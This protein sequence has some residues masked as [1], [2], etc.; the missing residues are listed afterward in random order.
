MILPLV[1]VTSCSFD[2]TTPNP[3]ER[4]P[5]ENLDELF[6]RQTLTG[7]TK[8]ID[9]SMDE[10]IITSSG[11][12]VSIEAGS[13]LKNNNPVVG[14][15]SVVT[16]ELML[17]SDMILLDKPSTSG[18]SILEYGAILVFNAF[19]DSSGIDLQNPIS[20]TL[21]INNQVSG[22]GDMNHYNR[23]GSWQ[24]VNNS[25]VVVDAGEMTLQF[26]TEDNGWMCGAMQTNFNDLTTIEA[27][28]F[29]YGTILTDIAGFVILSDF[30]TVIKMD[31]DIN[32]V[33]VSKSNIPKGVE[34]SIV[35]IAMDH[36]QL[37]IGIETMDITTDLS[38]EIKM[39]EV[40][41]QELPS[42][43]QMIN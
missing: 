6:A 27:S 18:N 22:L 3:K 7:E 38:L 15:V 34:A 26:D 14:N 23:S 2:D 10:T 11:A 5:Y 39:N 40:T 12:K 24:Q 1:I 19:K 16:R 41:E 35:I 28:P 25:P 43:L 31:S 4:L 8:I 30:N 17:K 21:P 9:A 33:K 42:V 20:V 32:G 13:F 37:F 36:F 29:G